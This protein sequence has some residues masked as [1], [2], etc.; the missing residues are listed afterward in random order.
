MKYE[1]SSVMSRRQRETYEHGGGSRGDSVMWCD[2]VKVSSRK[3][4]SSRLS[5]VLALRCEF[6]SSRLSEIREDKEKLGPIYDDEE[7]SFDYPH[8][9]PL[10]VARR[11]LDDTPGPIFDE[12]DDRFND[13]QGLTFDEDSGPIFDEED[14]HFDYPV[15][16]SLLV[17]RRSLSVQ[18]K[19]NE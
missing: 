13:D 4:R 7:E 8:P 15:H 10:L 14:D 19:T 17:T 2:R 5:V 16:G 6:M 3:C 9:G 11:P 18:P 12:E 1:R